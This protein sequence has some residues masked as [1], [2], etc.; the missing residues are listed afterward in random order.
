M[1]RKYAQKAATGNPPVTRRETTPS[2]A[3]I[4]AASVALTGD[5]ADAR[6]HRPDPD[7]RGKNA[8]APPFDSMREYVEALDY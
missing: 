3:A 6:S 8:P 4:A 2:G 1:D 5:D 7:M